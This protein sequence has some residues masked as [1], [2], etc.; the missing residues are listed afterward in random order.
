[1]PE[2]RTEWHHCVGFGKLFDLAGAFLK[3]HVAIEG[4]LRSDG[5]QREIASAPLLEDA[6][7]KEPAYAD[8]LLEAMSTE[9][10]TTSESSIIA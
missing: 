10:A 7:K 6:S 8:F 1:M 9:R 5:Y 3:A 4:E 2:S